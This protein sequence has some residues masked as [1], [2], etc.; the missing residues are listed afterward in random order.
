MHPIESVLKPL[1]SIAQ[2]VIID[3]WE[4]SLPPLLT[5]LLLMTLATARPVALTTTRP[6]DVVYMEHPHMAHGTRPMVVMAV[7]DGRAMLMP[8]TH[9]QC[10]ELQVEVMPNWHDDSYPAPNRVWA[11]AAARCQAARAPRGWNRTAAVAACWDAW[12]AFMA[13]APAKARR[14]AAAF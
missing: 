4:V 12:E 2:C 11:V 7:A 6:G 8:V 1:T 3:V 9:G 14:L 13:A 5:H 10:R